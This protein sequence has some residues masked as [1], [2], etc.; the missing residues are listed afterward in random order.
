MTK[1]V[2]NT[3]IFS[4]A[5]DFNINLLASTFL[6]LLIEMAFQDHLKKQNHSVTT[7]PILFYFVLFAKTDFETPY[8]KFEHF[9]IQNFYKESLEKPEIKTF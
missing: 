9:F 8:S 3:T 1:W 2:P 4:A 5:N 7:G 6:N